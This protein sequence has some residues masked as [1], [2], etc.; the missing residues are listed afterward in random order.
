LENSSENILS[1]KNMPWLDIGELPGSYD[2][3][4]QEA[5]QVYLSP[6]STEPFSLIFKYNNWRRAFSKRSPL[7]RLKDYVF[8]TE[9]RL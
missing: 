2:P 7:N 1:I 5:F 6:E 9:H 8:T 4:K 3:E